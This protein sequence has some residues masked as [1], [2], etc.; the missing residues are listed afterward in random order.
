MD[1]PPWATSALN[2]IECGEPYVNKGCGT[3]MTVSFFFTLSPYRLA[4]DPKQTG[5]KSILDLHSVHV[6]LH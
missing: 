3:T 1:D 2:Q 6:V 4:M 5:L